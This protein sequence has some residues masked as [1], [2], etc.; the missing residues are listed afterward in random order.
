[1]AELTKLAGEARDNVKFLATLERHFKSIT[2]GPLAGI[3]DTLP[4][5]MNALRM[6]RRTAAAAGRSS[7][8]LPANDPLQH[9]ARA[10]GWRPE[11][12]PGRAP[13]APP[14]VAPPPPRR[15]GSSASTTATTRAWAACSSA[16][17]PRSATAWS[18]P[19]TWARCSRC[20]PPR[21]WRSSARR[22]WWRSSGTPPTCRCAAAGPARRRRGA[23]RLRLYTGRAALWR[24]LLRASSPARRCAAPARAR[25]CA[26]Q[27][28]EKIEVSGRDARWE[29]SKQA[30]FACTNYAAEICGDLAVMVELV[31]DFFKFLGPELKAVTGALPG[32][33]AAGALLLPGAAAGALLGGG[34]APCRRLLA[35]RPLGGP[36][37]PAVPGSAA[38]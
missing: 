13:S 3:A 22:A 14:A 7:A 8:A 9:C 30:L 38:E 32:A 26:A 5:L 6:V 10:C 12:K 27:V 35:S 34:W 4:P 20:P 11:A 15:C 18:A 37:G 25:A 21:R 29:F 2:S 17:P 23:A 24:R 28:R 1:M 33:A 19:S 31:D 16:S 36:G